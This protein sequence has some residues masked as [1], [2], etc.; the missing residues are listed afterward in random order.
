MKG[1]GGW[2]VLEGS[3]F[4]DALLRA[5]KQRQTAKPR[6]TLRRRPQQ[7][8]E[9]RSSSRKPFLFEASVAMTKDRKAQQQKA[10]TRKEVSN[11]KAFW[12]AGKVS[13]PEY[14]QFC[15]RVHLLELQVSKGDTIEEKARRI[16][17]T[18][19][20]NLAGSGRKS[21]A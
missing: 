14:V 5:L 4:E 19:L 18:L 20:A 11:A 13:K 8:P 9:P 17:Q 16:K 1:I 2:I 3:V 21:A 10:A 6:I 7:H 15:N 12:R